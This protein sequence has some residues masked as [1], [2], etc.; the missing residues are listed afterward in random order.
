MKYRIELKPE[1]KMRFRALLETE[2]LEEVKAWLANP[3]VKVT[4]RLRGTDGTYHQLA[5]PSYHD[6]IVSSL[7]S[8]ASAMDDCDNI[9]MRWLENKEV[10]TVASMETEEG[11]RQIE[12]WNGE[13]IGKR[14]PRQVMTS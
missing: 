8:D 6:I 10:S 4:T 1:R 2:N 5:T 3:P 14:T 13:P 11:C 12:R 7:H 9:P